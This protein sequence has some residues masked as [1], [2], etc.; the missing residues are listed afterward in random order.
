MGAETLKERRVA[1]GDVFGWTS[2]AWRHV[3]GRTRT[4]VKEASCDR[5]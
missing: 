1:S 4:A 5:S 3:K 2:S